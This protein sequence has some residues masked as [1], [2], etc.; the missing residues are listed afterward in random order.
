MNFQYLTGYLKLSQ[1]DCEK[2]G[3][4]IVFVKKTLKARGAIIL[5]STDINSELTLSTHAVYVSTFTFN[6]SHKC[7]RFFVSV[8]L[9][10]MFE[11][12]VFR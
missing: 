7:C 2:C 4:G 8:I 6:Y 10:I 9:A 11:G 3:A 5:K 12:L 1:W